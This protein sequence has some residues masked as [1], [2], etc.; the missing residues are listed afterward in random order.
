MK[1]HGA[2]LPRKQE[3]AIAALI[4]SRNID[5]AAKTTGVSASTLRRWMRLS[6]FDREYKRARREVV[7]HAYARLQQNSNPAAG[8]LLKL[9]VEAKDSTKLQAAKC[10][11]E[12]ANKAL[13]KEDILAR[14]ERLEQHMQNEGQ[15]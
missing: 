6:E 13:D 14:L 7:S 9:M 1:G 5:E 4:T 12:L 2:K 3:A 15:S 10:V 8:L 11:L